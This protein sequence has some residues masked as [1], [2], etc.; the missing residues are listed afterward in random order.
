MRT[1]FVVVGVVIAGCSSDTPS[2]DPALPDVGDSRPA[3]QLSAEIK[4]DAASIA[5]A[6]NRFAFDLYGQLASE[7]GNLFFSPFS[8]STALAM[9]DAGAAG[10]TDQ[11]LRAALHFTLPGERTHAAYG[12]LLASL[13]IGRDRGAY[14]LATANRLFG[15]DGYPFLPS[16]VTLTQR[17]YGAP[18]MPVDFANHTEDARATINT[19][20]AEQTAQKIPELFESGQ[21]DAD[22]VLALANAIVFKGTWADKF[23]ASR[24]SDASF[25]LADGT[26]VQAR[27]MHRT[28]ALTQRRLDDVAWVGILPFGG[29]DLSMAIVLPNE[30][31]GLAA[32][33]AQL[34]SVGIT[35]LLGDG[36]STKGSPEMLEV[37]VPKFSIASNYKLPPVLESLGI[38]TAFQDAT[39]DFSAIDG[40]ADLVLGN[41]VHK[42]VIAID[43][44][45][46]E[47]AAATGGEA[48]PTSVPA[49]FI[50][51]RPFMFLIYDHVTGSILFLGRVVDP[52]T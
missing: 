43:E 13:Q 38:V 22:T 31:D 17:D 36:G 23:D 51:D 30:V 40:S 47:A 42:A 15:Q 20:V 35:E 25:H 8:I 18:L 39:A 29:H 1:L 52:R 11:E 49:P 3:R 24:T 14:T 41:V 5:A 44:D 16:F 32:V 50:V 27:T 6:N 7:P 33:E 2:D 28:G 26:T 48:Q 12:A 9:I 37:A 46:A 19:W 21:I 34:G 45:G 10:V 4:G